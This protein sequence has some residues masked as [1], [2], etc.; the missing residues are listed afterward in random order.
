MKDNKKY[1]RAALEKI[2]GVARAKSAE[3]FAR[4]ASSKSAP[5]KAEKVEPIDEHEEALEDE[6]EATDDLD[7]P[8]EEDLSKKTTLM[9][10]GR[11]KAMSKKGAPAVETTPKR[12]PG[13]PR[14]GA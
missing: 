3:R 11:G 13:R 12:K 10:I 14:K 6:A 5:P 8:E 7:E 1:L 2:K 9:F 4:K